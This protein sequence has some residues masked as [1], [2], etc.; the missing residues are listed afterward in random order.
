MEW[1]HDASINFS[2]QLDTTL[3]VGDVANL[4]KDTVI[5][6]GPYLRFTVG[7]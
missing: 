6:A 3:I 4:E 1:S 7:F 2:L 5:F